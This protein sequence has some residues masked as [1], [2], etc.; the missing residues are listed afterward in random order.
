MTFEQMTEINRLLP[1]LEIELAVIADRLIAA[2]EKDNH[3]WH[4]NGVST[5]LRGT[6]E[7]RYI[8][9]NSSVYSGSSGI[10]L[11]FNELYKHNKSERYHQALINGAQ[12]LLH[13]IETSVPESC[14][15]LAGKLGMAWTLLLLSETLGDSEL[16]Q[17]ALSI[18]LQAKDVI[19]QDST[20]SEYIHG[21]SGVI[22]ALI[23]IH[24]MTD[25]HRVLELL[26]LVVGALISRLKFGRKGIFFDENINQI[27]PLCGFSHGVS[28]VAFAFL[29]L[30]AYFSNSSFLTLAKLCFDFEDSVYSEQFSEWPDFRKV[31]PMETII[32]RFNAGDRV[33]FHFPRYLSTWCHGSIGIALVRLRAR[34]LG[35]NQDFR[36]TTQSLKRRMTSEV[37]LTD[38]YTLCHG[39]GGDIET[40]LVASQEIPGQGYESHIAQILSNLL[41]QKAERKFHLSGYPNYHDED[42]SLFMG[43]AGIGYQI[44]RCLRPNS[45]RPIL[46]PIIRA[47]C[48]TSELGAYANI[49]IEHLDLKHQLAS[50]LYPVSMSV[51]QEFDNAMVPT[52]LQGFEFKGNY[53]STLRRKIESAVACTKLFETD[54]LNQLYIEYKKN[55]LKLKINTAHSYA[56]FSELKV[57]DHI[58][59]EDI[60]NLDVCI[61]PLNIL[62][63]GKRTYSEFAK[64]SKISTTLLVP[65][66]YKVA[67]YHI[68]PPAE[69]ILSYF[70]KNTIVYSVIEKI[71]EGLDATDAA[72][73]TD[74]IV[75]QIREL[76]KYGILIESRTIL[77]TNLF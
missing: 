27:A 38:H 46:A 54:I 30:Y 74:K 47:R 73:T 14:S 31:E 43:S 25:N 26:D 44:L 61:N 59:Q 67:S 24:S 23:H 66:A 39:F 5:R 28:G 69:K 76:L 16:A 65:R 15:L 18:T 21:L 70:K 1:E 12:G 36:K 77:N 64:H 34:S 3:G 52:I 51:I 2:A 41:Q 63:K 53:R 71:S 33:F 50:R 7:E 4:W 32:E 68:T 10:L 20:P 17:K 72:V 55:Q 13:D 56:R 48:K 11:F 40:Y 57:Y 49:M 62:V 8:E 37:Q 42:H 60:L 6:K 45:C 19:L 75:A 22:V 58:K 35:I 9:R 29:E